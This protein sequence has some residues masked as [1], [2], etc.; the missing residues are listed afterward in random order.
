MP[1]HKYQWRLYVSYQKLNQVTHPFTFPIP[2]WD[3]KVQYI[4]TQVKYFIAVDMDSGYLQV[5]AEEESHKIL[6]F[7]TP[8][9]KVRCRLMT[10]RALNSSPIFV[11]MMMKLQME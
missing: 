11:A 10:M 4:E 9:G 3:E 5:F 8:D 6:S 7:F 2:V 1:W